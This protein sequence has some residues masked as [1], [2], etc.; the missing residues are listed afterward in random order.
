MKKILEH[1]KDVVGG[2]A[3]LLRP[4][5]KHWPSVRAVHLKNSPKC[6]AC[7]GTVGLEVHHVVPFHVDPSLELLDSNLVT[8]CD[9][10]GK[11]DCHLVVG[12]LGNFK[13]D[14]PNVRKDA[15]ELLKKVTT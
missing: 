14:N 2:K 13:K 15:A 3:K 5:S 10:P 12:H 11:D 8:L 6:I 1:L 9:K 4:R 7:G